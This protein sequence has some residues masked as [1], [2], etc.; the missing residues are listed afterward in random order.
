MFS[1]FERF[2]IAL[3][4]ALLLAGV[5]LILASAEGA[6]FS[7]QQ[8][9]ADCGVCHPQFLEVWL[10]GPHGNATIDPAFEEAWAEQGKPGA[11]LV[12]HTTGY[13]PATGAWEKDGVACE[14][15]HSP[16][17]DAHP[18]DPMP[19]DTSPDLCGRC[20]TSA[21][22]DWQD[23]E[24]STHYQRNMTCL[25]CHD[26]HYAGIRAIGTGEDEIADASAL[27]VNCHREHAMDFSYSVHHAEGLT[28]VD[29]HLR[30]LELG[31]RQA[32]AVLD[33]S[34]NASLAT[35]NACHAD[36]MHGSP[37]EPPQ[38]SPQVSAR[39]PFSDDLQR[40]GLAPEPEPVSP[41]GFALLAGLIG[42]AAGVI[43]APWMERLYHTLSMNVP[44]DENG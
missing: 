22:F 10:S 42:L 29:C 26:P 32:H 19:V 13:D 37:G 28:C 27:C 18:R 11:C 25:V 33:H 38:R 2:L 39:P 30:H 41:M 4:I 36:Q 21:R 23:W 15:C 17:P 40:S 16:V 12:C 8:Q 20:H 43:L 35:C 14:A 7:G 6:A 5:S 3:M 9:T 34:F 44:E 1:L 31:E 24:V